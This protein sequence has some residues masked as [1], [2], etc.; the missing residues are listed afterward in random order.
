MK[1]DIEL[2]LV[3][4]MGF[5]LNGC[6][7]KPQSYTLRTTR[8]VYD[9]EPLNS[10]SSLPKAEITLTKVKGG[11]FDIVL[12]YA[13]STYHGTAEKGAV[14]T[15]D[16]DPDILAGGRIDNTYLVRGKGSAELHFSCIYGYAFVEITQVYS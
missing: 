5:L 1:K 4:L 2:L 6:G 8:V 13:G 15:W 12:K 14:I 11:N 16:K 3:L 10:S 7:S 9:G